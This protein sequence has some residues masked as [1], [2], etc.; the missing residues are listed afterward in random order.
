MIEQTKQMIKSRELA[1]KLYDRWVRHRQNRGPIEIPTNQAQ[2]KKLGLKNIVNQLID[3]RRKHL[4]ELKEVSKEMTM[5]DK[6]ALLVKL[7][8][9]VLETSTLLHKLSMQLA[10]N[11]DVE[12]FSRTNQADN[13]GCGCGCGCAAMAQL[14]YEERI[15]A[16]MATKPFSVDPFN[17]LNTPARERDELL[18]KD[19][20][21]SYEA[22][23]GSVS[24]R[25][26]ARYFG[27]GRQFG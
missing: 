10:S 19:F 21:D 23:S 6:V 11:S 1:L 9:P 26:D 3:P 12:Y 5:A 22:L 4:K 15:Y 13:C 25:V 2:L 20:L 8:L 14:P 27:M 7:E 16:H 24:E 17:E 18:V